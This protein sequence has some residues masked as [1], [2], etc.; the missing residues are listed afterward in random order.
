MGKLPI[1]VQLYSVRHEA[2][3]DLAHTLEAVKA[4]GYDG[5]EFAG[6]Y[7]HDAATIKRWLD[8]NGLHCAGAHVGIDTLR[9]GQLE[10]SIEFAKVLG[11]P[12]LI[13][14][15]LPASTTAEWRAAAEELSAIS[16]ALTPH[17]LRTG[18]HNHDKEFH[19]GDDGILPWDAFFGTADPSVIMQ[20]DTGNALSGG[21]DALP[22]LTRYPGRAATVHLKEYQVAGKSFAPPVGEGDVPFTEIFDVCESTGG[23]DWYIVEYEDPALP[24]MEGI[25][26]CL[27]NLRQMGK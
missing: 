18:Y 13:V 1:A 4:M 9:G 19:P 27:A 24:A 5:V 23:T 25:A 20:F 14:P 3:A 7:G 2:E 11:N 15:W 22:F 16:R 10:S 17:G 26:R 12:Y 8:D 6:W 21:G